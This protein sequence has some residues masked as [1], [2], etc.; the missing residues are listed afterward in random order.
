MLLF[1]TFVF[2][3]LIRLKNDAFFIYRIG[4][5]E[6]PEYSQCLSNVLWPQ[7][8]G[9]TYG[10]KLIHTVGRCYRFSAINDLAATKYS[11]S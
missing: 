6:R 9:I 2:E 10:G 4:M 3:R 1:M 7:V 11:Y 8:E 5:T